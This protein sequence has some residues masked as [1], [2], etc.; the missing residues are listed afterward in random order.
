MRALKAVRQAVR[1]IYASVFVPLSNQ[2]GGK[3]V[4][5]GGDEG[6]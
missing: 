5:V 3:H 2:P 6:N 1:P 4:R